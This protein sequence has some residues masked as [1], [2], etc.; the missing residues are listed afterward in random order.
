M[1]FLW[2][3]SNPPAYDGIDQIKIAE[4]TGAYEEK[5]EY[6]KYLAKKYG[7]VKMLY[8]GVHFNYSLPDSFF[9]IYNKFSSLYTV[10]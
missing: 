10:N 2:T 7:K 6:R 9:D 3:Y 1:E 8:S 5:T 4:F